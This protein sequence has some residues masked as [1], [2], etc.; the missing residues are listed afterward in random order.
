MTDIKVA[1]RE[2]L[3][4]SQ[5]VT[6]EE[7]LEDVP[8]QPSMPVAKRFRP[9][10]VAA[11]A[12]VVVVLVIGSVWLLTAGNQAPVVTQP[13]Q[14]SSTLPQA[15]T[16][17]APD[18]TQPQA[19][20]PPAEVSGQW[21]LYS[22][23]QGLPRG[24]MTGVVVG[25]DGT[26]WAATDGSPV[27][28]Y[29]FDGT[30]WSQVGEPL[31]VEYYQWMVATPDGGVAMAVVDSSDSRESMPFAR[32]V[33]FDGDQWHN[34][35]DAILAMSAVVTQNGSPRILGYGT[36][37]L[38]DVQF[39][40]GA[41]SVKS[42]SRGDN[43]GS[44]PAGINVWD[45]VDVS[46]DGAA[47]YGTVE[48]AWRFDGDS[49]QLIEFDVRGNC[50]APLA[51]D[52]NDNVWIWLRGTWSGGDLFRLSPN[53]DQTRFSSEDGIPFLAE[54]ELTT[55]LPTS[56]GSVWLFDPEG[57]ARFDG[58]TWTSYTVGE[59]QAAGFPS[60]GRYWNDGVADG[61]DESIWIVTLQGEGSTEPVLH[62]FSE[63]QWMTVPTTG[64]SWGPVGGD[65]GTLGMAAS[66]D[67]SLWV[68]TSTGVAHFQPNGE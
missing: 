68:P 62:R 19:I 30:E 17:P 1:L 23:D 65:H 61:P 13:S 7:I 35:T 10:L 46:S 56:D 53:G 25:S 26:M 47:W 5:P 37:D 20:A 21:T 51:V 38:V 34:E 27:T 45:T 8:I 9:V 32:I 39:T 28:L 3:E 22:S 4:A 12:A 11:A 44:G 6:L 64:I 31:D 24:G 52:A 15:T 33:R 57:V 36:D 67:G 55:F 16:Q 60:D 63:G 29:R 18:T 2:Y 48:G 42:A 50:C 54:W 41:F 43:G 49:L 66:P 58:V 40:D 59:A 14:P